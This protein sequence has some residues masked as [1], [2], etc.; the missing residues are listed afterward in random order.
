MLEK[1]VYSKRT[2]DGWNSVDCITGAML[3]EFKTFVAMELE[4]E[5]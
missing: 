3:H 1:F 2:A 5:T 4:L